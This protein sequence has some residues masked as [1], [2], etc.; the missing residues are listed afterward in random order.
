MVKPDF[1]SS[2]MET[3]I[4]DK[5][6]QILQMS[7]DL[8]H[9]VVLYVCVSRCMTTDSTRIQLTLKTDHCNMFNKKM[10]MYV[11]LCRTMW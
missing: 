11:E 1:M 3:H 5:E 8:Q 2:I 9:V 10:A 6:S 4:L 7:F